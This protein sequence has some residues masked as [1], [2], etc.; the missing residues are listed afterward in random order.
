MTKL[1]SFL[2]S[3]ARISAALIL[4][5]ILYFQLTG[6]SFSVEIFSTLDVEPVGRIASGILGLIAAVL[7]LIPRFAWIGAFLALCLMSLLLYFH[8]T[9]FGT[10]IKEI[11]GTLLALSIL[12]SFCCVATLYMHHRQIPFFRRKKKADMLV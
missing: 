1:Q 3:I 11:G 12:V 6:A 2:S 10:E 8:L 9:V 4:F 5:Q 7:L